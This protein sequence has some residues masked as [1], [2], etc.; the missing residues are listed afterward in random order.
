MEVKGGSCRLGLWYV[1]VWSDGTTIHRIRFSKTGIEGNVPEQV[2]QY[3]AGQPVDLTTFPTIAISSDDSV[4][5]Q[6]YKAV[7]EIPYG[8]TATYGE[9]ALHIGTVPRVV[10]QAMARNPTPLVIPCHRVVGAKGIGGF[11]PDIGIKEMLLD[12]ERKTFQKLLV[13]KK[14]T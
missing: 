2:R 7:R 9:I 8:S 10:G 3:C 4:Y 13:A 11:S 1:H 14:A 5:G 12:M 6:I